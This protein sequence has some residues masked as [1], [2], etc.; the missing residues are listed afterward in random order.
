V[1]LVDL[2]DPVGEDMEHSGDTRQLDIRVVVEILE[3][4]PRPLERLEV[5]EQRSLVSIVFLA[6]ELWE[7]WELWVPQLV[8]LHLVGDVD[9]YLLLLLVHLFKISQNMLVDNFKVL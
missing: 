4:D 7:L 3:E 9:F 5:A 1:D 8:S 2:A 6:W